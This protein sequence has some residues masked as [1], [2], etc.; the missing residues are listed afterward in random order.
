M[1]NNGNCLSKILE[2]IILL[3]QN[4]NTNI[5]GC[6]K[7]FLGTDP[8]I[9]ANTRPINLY[10]CCTNSI[11]TIPYNYNNTEGSSSLFRIESLN[12][13]I[14][15]FRILIEEADGITATNDYFMIDLD[16]VSCIKC[17]NDV[18]ITNLE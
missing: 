7:P 16:Y 5:N 1:C 4:R 10:C 6:N 2:K 15:T 13:N 12:N 9:D 3:Q 14:A 18:L 17:L 8:T 11:W